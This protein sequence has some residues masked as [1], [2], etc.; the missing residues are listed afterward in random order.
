MNLSELEEIIQN[1]KD[2]V[3]TLED[4]VEEEK[5]L[6]VRLRDPDLLAKMEKVNQ[7]YIEDVNNT[8]IGDMQ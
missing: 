2:N 6:I 3:T 4:I 5:M 1:L 7:V 8:C